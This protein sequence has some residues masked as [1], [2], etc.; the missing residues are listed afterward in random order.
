MQPRV[1][2]VTSPKDV[3][4]AAQTTRPIQRDVIWSGR[5]AQVIKSVLN[6][7]EHVKVSGLH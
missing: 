6:T 3:L 4:S 5:S 2:N 7:E 1:V